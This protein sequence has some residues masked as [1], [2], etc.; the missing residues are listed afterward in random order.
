MNLRRKILSVLL[1]M[2]LLAFFLSGCAV[3]PVSGRSEVVLVSAEEERELGAQVA[4]EVKTSMGLVDDPEIVA[5]VKTV[6]RRLA[7]HSPRKDVRYT[8]QIVDMGEPNEIG[9]ASCRE[10]V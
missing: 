6:G 2:Y 4:E 1:G 10:R 3:N 5:Y 8:F 9:R 7:K